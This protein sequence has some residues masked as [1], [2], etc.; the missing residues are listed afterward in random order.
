V[1]AQEAGEVALQALARWERVNLRPAPRR[2]VIEA[3]AALLAAAKLVREA[4][5][6]DPP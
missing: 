2:A 6:S 4:R 5:A 3:E 1:T